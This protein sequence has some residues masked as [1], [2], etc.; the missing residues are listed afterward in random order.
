MNEGQGS[1]R[2]RRRPSRSS[3]PTTFGYIAFGFFGGHSVFSTTRRPWFRSS[4]EIAE[5]RSVESLRRMRSLLDR[6]STER[7]KQPA[8]RM[9]CVLH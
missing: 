9:K 4:A 5:A 2:R 1:R 6:L 8:G 7:V 3:E